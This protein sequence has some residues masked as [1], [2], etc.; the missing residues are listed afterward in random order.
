MPSHLALCLVVALSAIAW[1]GCLAPSG[2]ERGWDVWLLPVDADGGGYEQALESPGFPVNASFRPA[3]HHGSVSGTW[4]GNLSA[5]TY[6]LRIQAASA[7]DWSSSAQAGAC[8]SW[9]DQPC[10]LINTQGCGEGIKE[11][12][13]LPDFGTLRVRPIPDGCEF[14]YELTRD[15]GEDHLFELQ[16]Q[17]RLSDSGGE[18]TVQF[19]AG[20]DG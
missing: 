1:A 12:G 10:Y 19:L 5:G 17:V 8:I 16:W 4:N 13:G 9:N 2:P 11:S 14:R 6:V 20:R 15:V 18:R 7:Y 3:S